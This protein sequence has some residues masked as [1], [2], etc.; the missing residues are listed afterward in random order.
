MLIKKKFES[1][2]NENVSIHLSLLQSVNEIEKIINKIKTCISK[3]G[4]I[5]F[6]GNGGSAADAQ[7]LA[8][9]FLVRLRP[10]VNRK[11]IPALSLA[12]DTSTITACGNDYN[13]EDIFLRPFQAFANKNDILFCISTSGNSK[14]ILKVLKEAK[15][16]K[17]YSVGLLGADG[18]L[19]KKL[20]DKPL[21]I[22]SKITARIQECHIFLGHFILEKVEDYIISPKKNYSA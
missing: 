1:D 2:L 7:H 13:Y 15:K 12:Q 6:C 8:A 5:L 4:K 11:P 22:K 17:I 20:C 16:R 10:N 3:G 21:I 19:A 9:E 14:N 18:G